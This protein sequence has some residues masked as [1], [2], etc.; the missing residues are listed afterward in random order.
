[1]PS[2]ARHGGERYRACQEGLPRNVRRL[3]PRLPPRRPASARASATSRLPG[4]PGRIWSLFPSSTPGGRGGRIPGRCGARTRPRDF[5]P[6]CALSV[7]W[8]ADRVLMAPSIAPFADGTTARRNCEKPRPAPGL[9]RVTPHGRVWEDLRPV[10]VIHA[11][12]AWSTQPL[13]D[14]RV[15]TTSLMA[16]GTRIERERPASA[17]PVALVAPRFAYDTTGRVRISQKRRRRRDLTGGVGYRTCRAGAQAGATSPRRATSVALVL[18]P[19]PFGT[20]RERCAGRGYFA[21]HA[22]IG[23]G[24]ALA[25]LRS[26]LPGES[27]G[28]LSRK[29]STACR[30]LVL[31]L[32]FAWASRRSG[33]QI[34][35]TSGQAGSNPARHGVVGPGR[36]RQ[37]VSP[38]SLGPHS[39]DFAGSQLE[40]AAG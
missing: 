6:W 21:C 12:W 29:R 19:T 24:G 39:G 30:R 7:D 9:H 16:F 4:V 37:T 15:R 11:W 25:P 1:M 10:S 34:G 5:A 2:G 33:A 13:A 23:H 38:R 28:L 31:A 3:R 14:V 35:V 20:A 26:D 40:T 22:G 36:R 18:A 32:A 8:G 27:P 17:A